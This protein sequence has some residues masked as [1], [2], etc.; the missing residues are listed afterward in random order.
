M[1]TYLPDHSIVVVLTQK[2]TKGNEFPIACISTGLKA[3]EFKYLLVN[4]QGYALVKVVRKF[5]SYILKS[6]TLVI[7][8][9][10]AV[11]SMFT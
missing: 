6:H 1:P 3:T 9:H 5:R 8:T 11:R 4:K 7:V 10:P 2:K